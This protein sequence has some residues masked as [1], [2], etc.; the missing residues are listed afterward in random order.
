MEGLRDSGNSTTADSDL[1]KRNFK[2]TS[3]MEM[4]HFGGENVMTG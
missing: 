1:D 2:H 3:K 4:N